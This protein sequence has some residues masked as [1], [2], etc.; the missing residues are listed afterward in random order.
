MSHNSLCL[1]HMLQLGAFSQPVYKLIYTNELR[2]GCKADSLDINVVFLT[3]IS[4]Q[5]FKFLLLNVRAIQ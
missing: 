1:Y 2:V 5:A 3:F 4:F